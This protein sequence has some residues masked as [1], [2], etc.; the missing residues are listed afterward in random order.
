MSC[1]IFTPRPLSPGA[2]YAVFHLDAPRPGGG[3]SMLRGKEYGAIEGVGFVE[4]LCPSPIRVWG[5]C[6]Q[7]IF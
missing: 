2:L 6:P 4:G 1:L 7:K 3:I 5:L